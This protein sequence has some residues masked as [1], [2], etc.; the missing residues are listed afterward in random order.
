[1][2]GPDGVFYQLSLTCF[3]HETR[4]YKYTLCPFKSVTQQSFPSAPVHLGRRPRWRTRLGGVFVLK[5]EGG[6]VSACPGGKQRHT[7]VLYFFTASFC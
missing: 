6:D 4:E 1:M 7:L 3:D 2:Y 5:M